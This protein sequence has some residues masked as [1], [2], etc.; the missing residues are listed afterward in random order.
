MKFLPILLFCI[1]CNP[2]ESVELA[3]K[4][5]LEDPVIYAV[6]RVKSS[7]APNADDR[8]R[9]RAII[10][11]REAIREVEF[12]HTNHGIPVDPC[13]IERA[14]IVIPAPPRIHSTIDE[15][16]T[17]NQAA[18]GT[19]APNT[20]LMQQVQEGDSA[21][22]SFRHHILVE[23]EKY[24]RTRAHIALDNALGKFLMASR[25]I[26]GW[27]QNPQERLAEEAHRLFATA[28]EENLL[29]GKTV[30][31]ITDYL[32][33]VSADGDTFVDIALKSRHPEHIMCFLQLAKRFNAPMESETGRRLGP[34][35]YDY[36]LRERGPGA[37]YRH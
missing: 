6:R 35:L 24:S 11:L 20:I 4:E 37:L 27:G 19:S 5:S 7:F 34:S 13:P 28:R 33:T 3:H 10:A 26:G 1:L 2:A 31:R 12:Y 17:F 14:A 16:E 22:I 9:A 21:G 25:G 30:D 36:L 18:S 29:Y 32:T 15:L 8:K 23:E